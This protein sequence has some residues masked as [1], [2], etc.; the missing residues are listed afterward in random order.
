MNKLYHYLYEFELHDNKTLNSFTMW[1]TNE[2]H[3][4][5]ID[6]NISFLCI[7]KATSGLFHKLSTSI[8]TVLYFHIW[9]NGFPFEE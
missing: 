7:F 2:I 1:M 8:Y 6:K 4:I 3:S 9:I 5:I